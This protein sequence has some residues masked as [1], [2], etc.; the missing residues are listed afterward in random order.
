MS[1]NTNG[2]SIEGT[3]LNAERK[4]VPRTSVVVVPPANRRS[5]SA[6]Y[7]IVQS[8]AQG[9]FTISGIAPGAWKVFAWESVPANAFLNRD[10]LQEYEAQGTNVTVLAGTRAGVDISVIRKKTAGQ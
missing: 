10:F 7:K 5:N 4:P 2:G 3:E 9:R 8:D 6:L 1:I